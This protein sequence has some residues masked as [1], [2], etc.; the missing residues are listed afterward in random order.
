MKVNNLRKATKEDHL[1]R[2]AYLVLATAITIMVVGTLSVIAGGLHFIVSF[3]FGFVLAKS[4][5][6][7]FKH[8]F[9]ESPF[10][11]GGYVEELD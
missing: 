10:I 6:I 2:G 1:V 11:F 7:L 8:M 4:F 5:L 3:I 9:R